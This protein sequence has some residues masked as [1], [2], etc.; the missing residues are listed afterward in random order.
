MT[1]ALEPVVLD[2]AWTLVGPVEQAEKTISSAYGV[3]MFYFNPPKLDADAGLLAMKTYTFSKAFHSNPAP[4]A[5]AYA[6]ALPAVRQFDLAKVYRK[7]AD[8]IEERGV[9]RLTAMASDGRICAGA[10][11]RLAAGYPVGGMAEPEEALYGA[12]VQ[13]LG[14]HLTLG[15][16]SWAQRRAVVESWND[17]EVRTKE[18]VAATLRA[19]ADSI[20]A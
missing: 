13:W 7:A 2:E 5:P 16:R 17:N 6:P 4:V 14:I 12:F 20:P 10:A 9:A 15:I 3:E 1:T 8:L 11:I 18:A 19:F